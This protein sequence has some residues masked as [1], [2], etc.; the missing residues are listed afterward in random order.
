MLNKLFNKNW[1]ESLTA[2]GV[3]L[4]G[5]AGGAEQVG[6]APT[7]TAEGL[8]DLAQA[9]GGILMVLGIRRAATAPNAK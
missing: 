2:W 5:A 4:Y 3:I 6:V 8:L 1:Y 9:L 7:G